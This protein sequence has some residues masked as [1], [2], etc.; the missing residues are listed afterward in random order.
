MRRTAWA[1][2][3]IAVAGCGDPGGTGAD[4][5]PPPVPVVVRTASG[6]HRFQAELADTTAK[7]SAGMMYRPELEP[8]GAMLFAPYPPEGGPPRDASFWMR[9]TPSSLD[10]VFIRADR[11]IARIAENTVPMSEAPVASGEPIAA[12]L[13]VRGG[14]MAE[15][16]V[17]EGDRVEWPTLKP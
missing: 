7:Q 5:T 8:D 17:A 1:T 14:R 12:V 9:D 13:E 4:A 11:T 6:S 15:L 2:L 16:G 3:A 10:I